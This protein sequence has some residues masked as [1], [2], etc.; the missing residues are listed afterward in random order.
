MRNVTD[1]TDKTCPL[2][3]DQI[4]HLPILLIIYDSHDLHRGCDPILQ[5]AQFSTICVFLFSILKLAVINFRL[6]KYNF[7]ERK[8]KKEKLSCQRRLVS[9]YRHECSL[10][11]NW[12]IYI[13][14][15]QII[16]LKF[17]LVSWWPF[18]DGRDDVV[19]KKKKSDLQLTLNIH[20]YPILFYLLWWQNCNLHWAHQL[21]SWMLRP[22]HFQHF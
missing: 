2:L 15:L 11:I 18:D 22:V 13:A 16:V 14:D 6:E 19:K 17:S 10:H 1:R 20:I 8:K 4:Q 9:Y 12:F 3:F 5:L 21:L 7:T